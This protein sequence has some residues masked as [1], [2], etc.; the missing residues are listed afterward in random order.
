[1]IIASWLLIIAL[2]WLL[3]KVL[4]EK[5]SYTV[6]PRAL[7][8]NSLDK[9]EK[10]IAESSQTPTFNTDIVETIFPTPK[11]VV[12]SSISAGEAANY[13]EHE[14]PLYGINPNLAVC[15]AYNES[16]WQGNRIGDDDKICPDVSS[17]N[18]G[19]RE[20]SRGWWQ[21]SDCYHPEVSNAVAFSLV[22]STQWALNQIANGK[23]TQWSTYKLYCSGI[24]VFLSNVN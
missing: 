15:I 9:G 10:P 2:V 19:K 14:A 3:L 6:I 23:V 1:M 17:P 22:S 5:Y 18:Y 20:H 21:I 8:T 7:A 12:T 16:Q 11:K 24:P 4:N 13:V